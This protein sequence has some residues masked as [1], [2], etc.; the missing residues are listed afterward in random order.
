VG[1]ARPGPLD[2]IGLNDKVA[3][4]FGLETG[5]AKLAPWFQPITLHRYE[6]SLQVTETGPLMAYILSSIPASEAALAAEKLAA[7]ARFVENV[8]AE[9]ACTSPKHRACSRQRQQSATGDTEGA[10]L[11][12]FG[13]TR[14]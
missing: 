5:E 7:Y 12:V 4:R 10:K 11:L 9:G 3:G 13:A 6:D 8:L 14:Y 2:G 1:A